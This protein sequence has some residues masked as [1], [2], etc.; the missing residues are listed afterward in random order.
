MSWSVY[1]VDDRGHTEGDWNY[2]HNCNGMIEDALGAAAVKETGDVWWASDDMGHHAWW[3]LLDGKTDVEGHALIRA[4]LAG[5]QANPE[6]YR[7][8]NPPNGWGSYD[9]LV[10]VLTEM[11]ALV[12]EWPCSWSASG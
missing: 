12:P 4:I 7:A 3:R 8:M 2:T 9:S 10:G 1:L 5:L 6:K 11:C